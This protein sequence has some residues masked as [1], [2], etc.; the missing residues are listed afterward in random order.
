[1][2]FGR[3]HVGAHILFGIIHDGGKLWHF[4]PYLGNV[5]HRLLS[6]CRGFLHADTYAGF[7]KLYEGN[8]LT[9]Q[10]RLMQVTCWAHLW[11]PPV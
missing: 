10:P 8:E 7:D 9:G 6:E 11:T 5:A 1:M 4:R 2:L 3:G